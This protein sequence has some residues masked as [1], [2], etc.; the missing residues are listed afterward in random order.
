MAHG[1]QEL[2]TALR[3]EDRLRLMGRVVAG[4]A[5][6]I[7]NPLNSI[8]LTSRVLARR[9]AGQAQA[10]ESAG[11]ITSEIDRSDSL[12]SSLLVSERMSPASCGG[13]RSSRYSNARSRGKPHA[14]ERNV[15]CNSEMS[16]T[17]RQR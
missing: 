9:L 3:R 2:E 13:S 5:H 4:I 7:R 11:L 1:R 6:E 15:T 16:R 10:Q 12:L 17:A 8:R 14:K